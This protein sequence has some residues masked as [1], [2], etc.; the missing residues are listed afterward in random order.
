[1][2]CLPPPP[3]LPRARNRTRTRT[4]QRL[5]RASLLQP[6]TSP[7]ALALRHS[8]VEELVG[9]EEVAGSVGQVRGAGM[10]HAQCTGASAS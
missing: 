4:G 7:E 3:P 10:S 5:L 1:M 2:P 6:L 8:C 9:D